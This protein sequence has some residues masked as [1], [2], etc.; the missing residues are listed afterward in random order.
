MLHRTSAGIPHDSSGREINYYHVLGVS[1]EDGPRAIAQAYRMACLRCHPDKHPE[2][3]D[4]FLLVKEAYDTLGNGPKR[5]KYNA[6]NQWIRSHAQFVNQSAAVNLPSTP[7][8]RSPSAVGAARRGLRSANQGGQ[9]NGL[10][11][12]SSVFELPASVCMTASPSPVLRS[13]TPWASSRPRLQSRCEPH[14]R[15]MPLLVGRGQRSFGQA[16]KNAWAA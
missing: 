8:L 14:G 13:R 11:A 10:T 4:E 9:R 7:V 3:E 6:R 5:R 12:S 16:P 1:E 2:L 15:Q